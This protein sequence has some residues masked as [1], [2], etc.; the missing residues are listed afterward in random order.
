M[1]PDIDHS[2]P[3]PTPGESVWGDEA[4]VVEAVLE[5]VGGHVARGTDPT[6]TARPAAAL[7]AA[8]GPTVTREGIGH[9]RALEIFEQILQWLA[10]TP[11]NV[12]NPAVLESPR[13]RRAA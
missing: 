1:T 4:G 12:V 10:G 8:T 9:R 13:L 5:W 2:R 6:T 3:R 11:V 7:T